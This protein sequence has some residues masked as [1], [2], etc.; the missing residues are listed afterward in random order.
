MGSVVS[1]P[2]VL[3]FRHRGIVSDRWFCGKPMVI[4]GSARA[5]AVCE[6]SWDQFADGGGVCT[7]GYPSTLR[8]DDVVS[9]ARALIGSPYRLLDFNCEHVVAAAHGQTPKSPQLVL[10]AAVAVVA[11]I[12]WAVKSPGMVIRSQ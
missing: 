12:F 11:L 6:E 5:G 1:T 7:D 10:V 4:S 2:I 8:P 9:R 3:G